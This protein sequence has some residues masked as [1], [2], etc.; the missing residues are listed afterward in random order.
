MRNSGYFHFIANDGEA[1]KKARI[2]YHFIHN[3]DI[4]LD[5]IAYGMKAFVDGCV[6]AGLCKDDSPQY[7]T[8]GE[9]TF[10]KK[11]KTSRTRIQIEEI[12]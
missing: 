5:N 7:V 4:D 6:D 3:R 10:T 1:L 12:A 9:H 11:P 2:T 8:Y